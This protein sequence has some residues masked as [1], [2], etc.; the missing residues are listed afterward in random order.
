MIPFFPKQISYR[1]IIVYLI[2]LAL[3]SVFYFQ[4]AMS[5]GYMV[6]GVVCVVGFFLLTNS[7]TQGWASLSFHPAGLG[8]R[9]LFLL[10][11]CNGNSVRIRDFRCGRLS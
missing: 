11:G 4:Y 3:V 7:W 2:S 5:F 6:L 10:Y 8:C 9:V 1:A